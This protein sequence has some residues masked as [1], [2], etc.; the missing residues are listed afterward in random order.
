MYKAWREAISLTRNLQPLPLVGARICQERGVF[1]TLA[2]NKDSH[3]V[4]LGALA[5]TSKVDESVVEAILDYVCAQ[6]M[7]AHAAEQGYYTATKSTHMLLVPVFVDAVTH[8]Q[9]VDFL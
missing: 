5:T 2:A 8:F 4:S 7:A 3:G 9:Y 1:A 6:G